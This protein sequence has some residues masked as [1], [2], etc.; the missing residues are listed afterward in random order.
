MASY[1][2]D[3]SPRS[4]RIGRFIAQV[5]NELYKAIDEE[6]RASGLNQQAIADRLGLQRSAINRQLAGEDHLTLRSVA[7]LS[8]DLGREISFELR[9]PVEASGQN[10]NLNTTT[11]EW[12]RPKLVGVLAGA[13][14]DQA[15]SA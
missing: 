2:L 7:E 10:I 12:K 5:R 9:K 3:I 1:R 8:W 4:R 14:V 15:K 13:G 6:R 11:L